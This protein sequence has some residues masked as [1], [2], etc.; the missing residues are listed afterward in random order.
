MEETDRHIRPSLH[1]TLSAS[2]ASPLTTESHSTHNDGHPQSHYHTANDTSAG[3]DAETAPG[4]STATEL[5]GDGMAND[6]LLDLKRP[7]A[8]EA[9]RQ[10][11]VRCDPDNDNPDGPCKRCAKA[12]R[13][14]VVTAPTRKRQKKSD[15]RVAELEKK[16]DALTATLQAS[17]KR[18]GDGEIPFD[19]SE[20]LTPEE[21][22]A[23][24][25]W[26][27]QVSRGN[28]PPG[29]IA[30]SKRHLSGDIRS[31]MGN[32]EIMTPLAARSHS[33]T[34]EG[35]STASE[36]FSTSTAK[37]TGLPTNPVPSFNMM[38]TPAPK[39]G[40]EHHEY[41]DVIDRRVVDIETATK[42]FN[43]YVNEMAPLAPFI[44]F[45]PHTTMSDVRRTSPILFLSILAISI[46]AFE[47]SL[48]V[49]LVNEVHRTFAD[50]VIVR[51]TKSFELVK[52]IMV[53]CLWYS[54]PDHFEE[55]K[56]YQLIHMGITMAMDLGMN[57]RT[58]PNAKVT[59]I[60]RELMGKRAPYVE[61][62]SLDG[63]RVWLGCYF[64]GV[65]YIYF[66]NFPC[67]TFPRPFIFIF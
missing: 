11:K 56:I 44:V 37:Q 13:R 52:A 12:H 47:P 32:A 67:W 43:R 36:A 17:R 57:R 48:H 49:P 7:R 35:P 21:S 65:R 46:T 50:R 33:P 23:S 60:L 22:P 20:R 61:P 25:R 8:C 66:I 31:R 26:L 1:T 40:F 15:S 45:P 29:G 2:T 51:G 3:Y 63:R 19:S 27:G 54:P 42:S 62:E 53:S 14:C 34:G 9:C 55:L 10:L 5:G 41:A 30:G 58:K 38:F 24:S 39:P 28:G 16:I 6:P 64:M 18:S 4:D 59:G